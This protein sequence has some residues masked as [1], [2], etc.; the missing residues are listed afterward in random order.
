MTTVLLAGRKLPHGDW[1]GDS[2]TPGGRFVTC[3]DCSLGRDVAYATNGGIVKDGRVY[4]AN[5]HPHDV[6]G[7]N[8]N[9]AAQACRIVTG[10][11]LVRPQHWQWADLLAHLRARRGAIVQGWYDAI[12]RT[13]RFQAGADFG[14]AVF[15]SHYSPTSGMRVWD[16]LDANTTHHGSWV[17]ATDIRAGMEELARINGTHGLYV[18]YVPLQPL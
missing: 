10:L 16:A 6:N 11:T 18:G 12:P 9:Q 13:Y 7:I 8:L 14:H 3:T 2:F 15:I 17:P 5:V 4:R 1:E